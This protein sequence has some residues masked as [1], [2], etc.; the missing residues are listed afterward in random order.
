MNFSEW[1]KH[2]AQAR[3]KL[4]RFYLV[5]D[6]ARAMKKKRLLIGSPSGIRKAIREGRLPQP[7]GR[8]IGTGVYIW[9]EADANAALVHEY[10]RLIRQNGPR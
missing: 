7:T 10:E 2:M 3:K 4:K 6:L 8:T 5:E 9:S 1:R